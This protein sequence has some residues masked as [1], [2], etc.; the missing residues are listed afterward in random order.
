[1]TVITTDTGQQYQTAGALKTATGIIVGGLSGHAIYNSSNRLIYENFEKY[2]NTIQKDEFANIAQE[3]FQKS[4]LPEKGVTFLTEA[5]DEN[6]IK[7]FDAVLEKISVFLKKCKNFYKNNPKALEKIKSKEKDAS[8]K[9]FKDIYNKSKNNSFFSS[10][11]N[12]IMC[13]LKNWSYAAFHEMGHAMNANGNKL[14]KIPL[15]LLNLKSLA[16]VIGIIALLKREKTEGEQPKGFWDK[17]TTF[18]KNNAGILAF[19]TFIPILTEETIA[20]IRGYKLAKKYLS[21]EQLK[22]IG[23][24]QKKALLTYIGTAVAAGVGT[25][26]ASKI[27]DAF[28]K[29]KELTYFDTVYTRTPY[30]NN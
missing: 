15:K 4:G 23:T 10:A 16:P 29:P 13:D 7:V 18:I 20:S 27:R 30:I 21:P 5:N 24:F 3:A 12:I 17:T 1:M 22:K 8:V 11:G 28:S 9:L 14:A 25:F 19:S 2:R 26:L 6:I